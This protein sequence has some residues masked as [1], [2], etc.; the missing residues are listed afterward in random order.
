MQ[1]D[2]KQQT[3]PDPK[4]ILALLDAP[5]SDDGVLAEARSYGRKGC[6][7]L[8]KAA[9]GDDPDPQR[10]AR[11]VHLMGLLRCEELGKLTG[12]LLR[13]DTFGVQVAAVYAAVAADASL[14]ERELM[15]LIEDQKVDSLLREHAVQALWPTI[16]EKERRTIASV[17]RDGDD[18]RLRIELEPLILQLETDTKDHTG[19][20]RR[21]LTGD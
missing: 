8:A 3:P 12:K 10:R 16:G 11:A 15:P 4:R 19:E 21:D 18:E 1:P 13:K 9:A 6:E 17:L 2:P 5:E 20:P 7:L 14:A